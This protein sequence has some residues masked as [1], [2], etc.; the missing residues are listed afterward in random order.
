MQ[1][2]ADRIWSKARALGDTSVRPPLVTRHGRIR[3]L[4]LAIEP[5]TDDELWRTFDAHQFMRSRSVR[6]EDLHP[7]ARISETGHIQGLPDASD[8]PEPLHGALGPARPHR[9]EAR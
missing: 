9:G 5:E 8:Q 7:L 6:D 3:G 1:A 4:V 2:L